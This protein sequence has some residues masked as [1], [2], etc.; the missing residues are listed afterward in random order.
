M[1]NSV[2]DKHKAVYPWSLKDAKKSGEEDLWRDSYKENCDCARAIERAI[3][4]NFS[5]NS[6]NTDAVSGIIATYGFDRVKFVLSNT[7]QRRSEDGR[8]SAENKEWAKGVYIPKDDICWHY[9]VDSHSGLTNLFVDRVRSEW[10]KL[11]LFDKSH[12]SDEGYYEDKVLVLKPSTLKDEYKTPDF[13]L[14]YAQSGFGCDPTKIGTSI[15]GVFLYDDEYA[16]F[17]RGDFLGVIK[18]EHLPDWAKEKLQS[19]KEVAS[20]TESPTIT[21]QGE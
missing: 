3:R 4:D 20:Q 7:I 2:A 14:F 17:R 10:D 9:E 1:A 13:Q 12:C 11:K 16:H 21:M 15:S 18:D 8:I 5:D 6:L 19:M